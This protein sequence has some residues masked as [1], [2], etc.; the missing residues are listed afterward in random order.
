[1]KDSIKNEKQKLPVRIVA[2][3]LVSG[4]SPSRTAKKVEKHKNNYLKASG[5]FQQSKEFKSQDVREQGSLEVAFALE[6]NLKDWVAAEKEAAEG[7]I[8]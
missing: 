8:S 6:Q 7:L 4:Q 5:S 1:M 3:L 2:E